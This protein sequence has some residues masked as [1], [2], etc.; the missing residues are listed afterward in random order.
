MAAEGASADIV[1]EVLDIDEGTTSPEVV[2]GDH[3][4]VNEMGGGLASL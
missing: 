1:V 4:K 2:K 3:A